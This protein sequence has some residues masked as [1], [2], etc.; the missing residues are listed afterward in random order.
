MIRVDLSSAHK[1]QVRDKFTIW[2]GFEVVMLWAYA[3]GIIP[4]VDP[5]EQPITSS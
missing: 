3:N 4:F 2:T 1:D 5:R